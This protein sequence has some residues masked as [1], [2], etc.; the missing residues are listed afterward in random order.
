MISRVLV[1]VGLLQHLVGQVYKLLGVQL[2]ADLFVLGHIMEQGEDLLPTSVQ[3][4]LIALVELPLHEQV[5]HLTLVFHVHLVLRVLADRI[6]ESN[7]ALVELHLVI[8]GEVDYH[9]VVHCLGA[10]EAL[11]GGQFLDVHHISEAEQS[12]DVDARLEVLR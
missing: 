7:D 12:I 8:V 4:R 6:Q 2:L 3:G 10:E 1:D 5:Q 9:R 11:V